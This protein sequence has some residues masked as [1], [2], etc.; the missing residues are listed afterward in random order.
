MRLLIAALLGVLVA[1]SPAQARLRA[2]GR[3]TATP[4]SEAVR[5]HWTDCATGETRY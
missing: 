2:V 4:S 5:L 3:L 1:A